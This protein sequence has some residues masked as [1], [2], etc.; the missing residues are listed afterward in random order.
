[1]TSKHRRRRSKDLGMAAVER[2]H[3]EMQIDEPWT[4]REDRGFTWWGAWIRQRV[5]SGPATRSAGETLW[6]VRARAPVFRDQPDEPAT[7]ARVADWNL[8]WPMGAMAYDP[9]DGTISA[10]SGAFLYSGV[11]PWLETFMLMATGLQASLA[12]VAAEA[13]EGVGPRDAEPHP[14]AG[15]RRDPD[16]MLNLAASPPKA[17]SPI[18][19]SILR[20][21]GKELADE[22][23]AITFD[24][25]EEVL[26]AMVPVADES[27]MWLLRSVDHP[28]LGPGALARLVLPRP[29]GPQRCAWLANALNLGEAA[30]WT[31]DVRPHA[32]GAWSSEGGRLAH[33]A[34][35]P[36]VLLGGGDENVAVL[37]A[38]NFALWGGVRARFAGERLPWLE[39]AAASR[40]PDDE[41]VPPADGDTGKDPGESD[42]APEPVPW[43]QRSFGRASRTPRPR[44]VVEAGRPAREL[45]VDPDDPAAFGEIDDAVAAA[46]DGDRILVRPGTYRTPVVVD[47]AVRI[48]GDGAPAAIVL[49]PVGGEALGFAVSGASV[50]G[51]TI[52]PARAGNDGDEWSAVAVHDVEATVEGCL[53]SS[54]LGA[55]VWV[56][57]PGSS[58]LVLGCT[59]TDGAQNGVWVCEE[60]R[61][62]VVASR[63]AGNRWTVVAAGAHAVLE[64]T[65]S[66]IVDNLDGGVAAA[67]GAL[68]VMEGSTVAGNA[69]TGILL[70]AAAPSSR[71]EDCTVER[72]SG[73]GILL[74][75]VR[76]CA[77]LRNRFRDNGI[78]IGVIDGATP[79]V[80]GN[81]LAGNG[82]GIGVRGRGTDPVVIG[83]TVAGTRLTGIV[84]DEAAG[85]RFEGNTV[86]GAGGAGIWVDDA[87]SAPDFSGN[88]V[89]ASG[90][91]GVLVTDGAGGRYRSNDLRGNAAGS[92]KLDRPGDL[93]RTGNLEDTG[94]T[95]PDVPD[96]PDR[97]A[98]APG[99]L[100]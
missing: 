46:E 55:T 90:A 76:G 87:G 31:G 45:V 36:G 12:W 18:T 52:R 69:G 20:S 42:A 65:D 48:E 8:L 51:L 62:R 37:F 92:W 88:H 74:A 40:Y 4:V 11:D 14:V 96:G 33:N 78:G 3:R 72:N 77:V 63:I 67:D 80:E 66:E 28:V 21:A 34:F 50:E 79:R 2:V 100:N 15:P 19:A 86:S 25:D 97:P 61:A 17:P 38:R 39:A 49:E 82:T 57:G 43:D 58:A 83:N 1:M 27:A 5:W 53:L 47:R 64:I 10:R 73:E 93:E 54:H 6:H 71:V 29:M 81:D 9:D 41:P 23:F 84:V 22:G 26:V 44:A 89:S 59:I 13:A 85:G 91:A 98:G 30:D 35:F 56:G 99:R 94:R 60:G 7:Y 24:E 32:F 16:D 68:L 75:A 95:P 70:G